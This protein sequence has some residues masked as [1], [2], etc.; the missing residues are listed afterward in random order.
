MR[1]FNS[2]YKVVMRRGKMWI[3]KQH[4]RNGKVEFFFGVIAHQII[5]KFFE[6]LFYG[7]SV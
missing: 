7:T 3:V 6:N 4:P 2:R 1:K 5:T